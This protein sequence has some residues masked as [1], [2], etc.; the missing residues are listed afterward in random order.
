M[1]YCLLMCASISETFSAAFFP[2]IVSQRQS[3]S[4]KR[5]SPGMSLRTWVSLS[6][7]TR[8][9]V[10]AVAAHSHL[11]TSGAGETPGRG[12][13][14]FSARPSA[15]QCVPLFT[16]LT[17]VAGAT[18]STVASDGFAAPAIRETPGV[19]SSNASEINLRL[20]IDRDED[21][22]SLPFLCQ[23]SDLHFKLSLA[24]L[25]CTPRFLTI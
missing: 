8:R 23:L 24:F 25:S 10:R 20:K 17:A 4:R 12:N 21:L 5:R 18:V 3:S 7:R 1:S 6:G 2:D 11:R 15:R 16:E 22:V 13:F 9:A 19:R 14:F